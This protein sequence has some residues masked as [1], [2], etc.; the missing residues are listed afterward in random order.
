MAATSP[1]PR[2]AAK[3][4]RIVAL[5]RK[6]G[7][8]VLRDPSSFAIGV[9]L[10][11]MLILLFGYAMSLDVKHVPVAVVLEQPSSEASEVAAGFQLS[12]YFETRLTRSM[13]EAEEL[14]LAQKVDGIVHLPADFARRAAQGDANIEVVVYGVDANRGRF[15]QAYAQAAIAQAGVRRA[16][17]GRSDPTAGGQAVVESQLWFN[18]ANDSRYFLVPGLVVLIMTLI[19]AFMTSM[20]V[21]RE[22]ER[23]TFEALFVTPVRTDEI[24]IA[25]IVPYF[26]LGLGGLLLCL[27]SARLLFDVPIRGSILL[28]V[29]VS[30]LYLLV[31]VSMGLLISASLKGQFLSS[32][33]A[34][35]VTFMPAL[36]LSGFIYDLRGVPLAVRLISYLV[37]ARYYVSLL[38]SLFLAGDVWS[39]IIPNAAVLAVFAAVLLALTRLT[40]R[41][42]LG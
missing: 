5:I 16:A 17:E 6:E 33:V 9:V 21:A 19:G 7:R 20:V 34:L 31:S 12:P 38:Q 3:T 28:L 42:S 41:K 39:V 23:G 24:L 37:P 22:W 14:M 10:P 30:M 2:L 35:V 25:K 26:L 36:M 8:Q 29:A 1:G 13:A 4:S 15:I 27:G 40:T 18:A 11:L 32:Q